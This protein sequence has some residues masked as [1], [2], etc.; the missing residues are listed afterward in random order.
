MRFQSVFMLTT[1]GWDA[2]AGRKG[3]IVGLDN[4]P[5]DEQAEPHAMSL[6]REERIEQ[7]RHFGR[8]DARAGI[9]D[10]DLDHAIATSRTN[11]QETP[12][13]LHTGH[14]IHRVH[15]QVDDGLLQLYTVSEH[16]GQAGLEVLRYRNANAASRLAAGSRGSRQAVR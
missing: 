9:L 3:P 1:A 6:G 7:P 5:R 13:R 16:W 8:W 11:A 2:I 12:S 15:R 14:R 4:R 10:G